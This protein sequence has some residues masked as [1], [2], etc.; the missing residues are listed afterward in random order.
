MA[1]TLARDLNATVILKGSG[2]I[3]TQPHGN[4]IVNPTGNPA[5]ATAGSGD[6]L[7]GICGALLAQGWPAWEAALAATWMHGK[8]A[9]LLVQQG[10]GPIGLTASELIA[11]VRGVLNRLTSKHDRK[12]H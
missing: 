3:I 10:I 1:R 2:S 11:P 7:A 12:R 6:V 5:L 4:L 8:A 9:D